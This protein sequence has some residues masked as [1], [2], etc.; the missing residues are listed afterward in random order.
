MTTCSAMNTRWRDKAPDTSVAEHRPISGKPQPTGGD[1]PMAAAG[2][3]GSISSAE[4][5]HLPGAHMSNP[6]IVGVDPRR[7]D[8]SPLRLAAALSRITEQP[9]VAIASYPHETT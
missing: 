9:L 4:S 1:H 7:Q 5:A 2:P 3:G 8:R 6:I